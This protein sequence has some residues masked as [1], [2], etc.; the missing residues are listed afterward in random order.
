MQVIK[1]SHHYHKKKWRFEKLYLCTFKILRHLKIEEL[2]LFYTCF[3]FSK[4]RKTKF[5]N[6]DMFDDDLEK[7]IVVLDVPLRWTLI[8]HGGG[9]LCM[10]AR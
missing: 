6:F 9:E 2:E 3:I 8:F 7:S 4:C 1:L 10:Q 5:L